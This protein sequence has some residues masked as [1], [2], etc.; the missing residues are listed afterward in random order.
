M[1]APKKT[2][3]GLSEFTV[4]VLSSAFKKSSEGNIHTKGQS[5][6]HPLAAN[7]QQVQTCKYNTKILFNGCT[8]AMEIFTPITQTLNVVLQNFA[9]QENSD[10]DCQSDYACLPGKQCNQTGW[11]C[12]QQNS[13]DIGIAMLPDQFIQPVGWRS[14]WVEEVSFGVCNCT[15]LTQSWNGNVTSMMRHYQLGYDWIPHSLCEHSSV[16][17]FSAFLIVLM[18]KNYWKALLSML[19]LLVW[20]QSNMHKYCIL[21]RMSLGKPWLWLCQWPKRDMWM[22]LSQP[23]LL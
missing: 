1:T 3:W 17:S 16:A 7:P 19:L 20:I 13:H 9:L 22:R 23:T 4:A 12:C 15:T 2:L 10:D 5:V 14:F 11:K 6:Q 8:N 21:K 18:T